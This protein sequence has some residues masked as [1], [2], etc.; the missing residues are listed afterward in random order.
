M[1]R[2]R[3][4]AKKSKQTRQTEQ[5]KQSMSCLHDMKTVFC[6]KTD[7][8]ENLH[9]IQAGTL[10][11]RWFKCVITGH[12]DEDRYEDLGLEAPDQNPIP[13]EGAHIVP[14]SYGSWNAQQV[15]SLSSLNWFVSTNFNKSLPQ[16]LARSWEVLYRCFPS[17][18]DIRFKHDNIN[19]ISNGLN[20]ADW[21]HSRF[22]EFSLAFEATVSTIPFKPYTKVLIIGI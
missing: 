22:M 19:D 4:L 13:V 10:G 14:F 21:I 7:I 2:R 3:R 5:S 1:E 9:A 11:A 8:S 16:D 6:T 17:I 20:M 15:K 18:R 12:V